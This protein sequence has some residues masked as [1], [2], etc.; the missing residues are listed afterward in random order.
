MVELELST[1]LKICLVSSEFTPLA[2]TGGLADV[3]S[4]LSIFLDN[5]GHDVRV[6]IPFYSSIDTSG[7]D[8][9][10]VDYLQDIPIRI[11][12]AEGS[13]SIDSTTLP[14]SNLR[15]YLLRCPDLY[16]RKSLYTQDHDE[17][18]RFI[19]LAR[20]AIEM[21][22]RMSFA[23]DI[24]SCHDWHTSLI[25]L[26]LKTLYAWDKLFANTKSTLT[27]HN[28]GYQGIFSA[29]ILN[30]LNLSGY[31]DKLHQDDLKKGM[32]N[33]LK[34]G[35]L[36]ADVL[37]T[38]SPTYAREIQGDE[39][40]MGL[41]GLLQQR[42][43]S[44]FGILNGVDG[45]EWNPAT[46]KLLPA[47]YTIDDLSGKQTC[48]K[49]LMQE[50]GLKG[51]TD[52]PVIGIVSRMVGQK[53][54]DLMQSVLPRLLTQRN[55]SIAIL[56]S[57]EARFENFF[58]ELQH[59]FPERVTFYRGY[60]NKLAHM[61]EAGSDM[62]LM[63]SLYEPCGLNQ[64][65]SLK[66]GTVPIVRATGGLADSVEQVDP[67]S[68]SGTG[69]LF[70]DYNQQ[71][72]TWAINTALDLYQNKALWKKIQANGMAKDFSWETQGELYVKLFRKLS[73][74]T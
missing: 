68:Q 4:A 2:K 56:G 42:Q 27:I 50:L 12:S 23:P 62:F 33:F 74:I 5:A 15:I 10:P 55:F 32:I 58:T 41:Q 21:C 30:D 6:L 63:P 52:Q 64:M 7:L 39:Y 13:Y 3:A 35:V 53:G 57:G 25:P 71:G 59:A 46:D 26:Y 17:Q 34:T 48:K 54:M 28:I 69:I 67:K 43:E 66:Y 73:R 45:N 19:L 60:N 72:L 38:V 8:I 31:E 49:M 14:D 51:G 22:Q 37:T 20:A 1:P 11:G 61:I 24:F 36:Y 18:R 44:L 40:G 70:N 16:Q 47:N 29:D 65:Y 9:V